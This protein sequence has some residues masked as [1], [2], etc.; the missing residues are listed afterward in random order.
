MGI[1]STV[2]APDSRGWWCSGGSG[3]S[4]PSFR[5]K[6][7]RQGSITDLP[8]LGRRS[9]FAGR[10]G[11]GHEYADASAELASAGQARPVCRGP[12][13]ALIFMASQ[14]PRAAGWRWSPGPRA[15]AAVPC[16]HHHLGGVGGVSEE[17]R[18]GKGMPASLVV[19]QC[20]DHPGE[21][22]SEARLASA[23]QFQG[24]RAAALNNYAAGRTR[25]RPGKRRLP[26]RG[27]GMAWSLPAEQ[28][29]KRLS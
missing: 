1:T 6:A 27:G 21:C 22:P 14:R 3:Q 9:L 13:R 26:L 8:E 20:G 15:Q 7:P 19:H 18:R 4:G 11:V 24:R 17:F 10:A 29:G 5:R 25:G 12:G 2:C 23:G 28:P 16:S